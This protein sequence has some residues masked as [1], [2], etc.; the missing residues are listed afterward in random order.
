MMRFALVSSPMIDVARV[1]RF[2]PSNYTAVAVN[3]K[4]EP[5]LQLAVLIAGEDNFGWT[6]DGYVIPRLASGMIHAHE[7]IR[8]EAD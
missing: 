6:L 4:R 3:D 5:P 7:L 1:E 2:L 8:Q